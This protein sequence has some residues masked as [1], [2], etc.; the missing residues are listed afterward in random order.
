[1]TTAAVMAVTPRRS[2]VPRPS[3]R[4]AAR[5]SRAAVPATIRSSVAVA[6]GC[7]YTPLARRTRC[8]NT[9]TTA[10]ATRPTT[11]VAVLGGD[12]HGGDDGHDDQAGECAGERLGDGRA[13]A[14]GAGYGGCDVTGAGHPEGVAGALGVG[15]RR[16][17]FRGAVSGPVARG[18]DL[19]FVFRG[20]DLGSVVRGAG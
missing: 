5:A 19:R 1:M 10:A 12:E 7:T 15:D 18:A 20:V 13:E 8:P 4:T 14:G 3:A 6:A 17:V 2:S 16:H 9:T 11:N